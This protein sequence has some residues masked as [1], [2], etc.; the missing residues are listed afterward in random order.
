MIGLAFN[1]HVHQAGAALLALNISAT[2]GGGGG[3]GGGGREVA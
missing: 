3:G 2:G 1:R